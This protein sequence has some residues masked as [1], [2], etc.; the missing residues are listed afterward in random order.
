MRRVGRILLNVLTGLSLL[1]CL[2][3][4]V[5][6][7][8]SYRVWEDVFVQRPPEYT[9]R[10]AIPYPSE[11]RSTGGGVAFATVSPSRPLPDAEF[12]RM[13]SRGRPLV[14]YERVDQAAI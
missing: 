11:F 4:L 14:R 2:A 12:R 13:T 5:L 1:L 7:V 3:V 6:W 8:R 9:R 10:W